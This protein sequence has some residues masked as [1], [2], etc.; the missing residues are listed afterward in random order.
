MFP[1]LCSW[2]SV[3]IHIWWFFLLWNRNVFSFKT[4]NCLMS[5]SFW[6]PKN[7][8]TLEKHTHLP[9]TG[10]LALPPPTPRLARL[11]SGQA[12]NDET[13]SFQ[14]TMRRS[15]FW[16]EEVTQEDDAVDGR[17]PAPVDMVSIPLFT[18]FYKPQVVQDFL[19]QQDV[20]FLEHE[21]IYQHLLDVDII[22]DGPLPV[23]NGVI[24]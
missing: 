8:I 24:L 6:L 7:V 1:C 9:F 5:S 19:H 13:L 11:P 20:A 18:W 15:A 10:V 21:S 17:N 2:R 14:M 23:I 12:R 16:I 22:R 3:W 4:I